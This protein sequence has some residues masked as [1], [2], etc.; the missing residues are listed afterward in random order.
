MTP[1]INPRSFTFCSGRTPD[2]NKPALIIFTSGS[3]GAPKGAAVRRYNI[4]LIAMSLA[5]KNSICRGFSTVQLL[6]T[7]HAT[8]LMVN[9]LPSILGGGT[10]E[11]AQGNFDPATVWERFRKGDVKS[12]SAVPTMFI[13]LLKHWEDVL[14]KL[15][16]AERESYQ[17]AVSNMRE[18]HSSTS[19]L[20]RIVG[21]KWAK[22][23]RG[24][25][26]L[27]RYGGTEFGNVYASLP[28]MNVPQVSCHVT[29]ELAILDSQLLNYARDLW[30]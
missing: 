11:F 20:P 16:P 5:K 17:A 24:V 26:I 27:E 10:I 9:T 28:G 7:H 6:P 15:P 19:A 23:T 29:E 12:F 14:S 1:I 30:V 21:T 18:F 25:P 22:M 3:T 2:Q 8:G 13:L 4:Y